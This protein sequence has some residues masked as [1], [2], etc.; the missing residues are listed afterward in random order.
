MIFLLWNTIFWPNWSYRLGRDNTN[1]YHRL[2]FNF[3]WW[4]DLLVPCSL[5][6]H[7]IALQVLEP[8]WPSVIKFIQG[9]E[10]SQAENISRQV[11]S[12]DSSW[13]AQSAR[14]KLG[15]LVAIDHHWWG[16]WSTQITS[17]AGFCHSQGCTFLYYLN[18]IIRIDMNEWML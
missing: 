1:Y 3:H 10:L 4:W 9:D 7:W 17:L 15:K 18:K 16:V 11:A 12:G 2:L 5:R 14:E 8:T 13:G 6:S